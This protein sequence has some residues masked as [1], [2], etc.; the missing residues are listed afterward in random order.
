MKYLPNVFTEQGVAMLSSVIN[1]PKAIQVNI[2]I[3]RTFVKLRQL[4]ASNAELAKKINDLE[5]KYDGQFLTVF[6]AIRQLVI[7]REKK[8]RKIGFT[9]DHQNTS[10]K[11]RL[12][13]A[14][15]QK[16]ENLVLGRV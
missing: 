15:V 4:M 6:E 5:K 14:K 16:V 11:N 8:Q 1:S 2:Q 12:G 13:K 3:M 10:P 7:P 9:A